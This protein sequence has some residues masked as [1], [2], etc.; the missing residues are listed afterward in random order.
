VWEI[1]SAN[2]VFPLSGGPIKMMRGWDGL[3]GA[4]GLAVCAFTMLASTRETMSKAFLSMVSPERIE[5]RARQYATVPGP[6]H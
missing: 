3:D 5:F 4:V 6:G 1:E 2:V